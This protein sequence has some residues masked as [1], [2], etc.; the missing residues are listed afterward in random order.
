MK[1]K[2]ID[3]EPKI[4][5]LLRDLS[6]LNIGAYLAST[7]FDR[8]AI[9][10]GIENLWN[11]AIEAYEKSRKVIVL[12]PYD[13]THY[14][15]E[16]ALR[17]L[18]N[19]AIR[20]S[21]T[22]FNSIIIIILKGYL[23]WNTQAF[24]FEN[25]GEDLKLAGVPVEAVQKL[26]E[27]HNAKQRIIQ[28]IEAVQPNETS[29]DKKESEIAPNAFI[30]SKK[31]AWIDK[32]SKA[33][34]EG[35]LEDIK[36]YAKENSNVKLIKEIVNLSSRYHRIKDQNNKGTLKHEEKELEINKINEALVELILSL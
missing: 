28:S 23:K 35:T 36:Y 21:Q 34:I 1:I 22:D 32:T 8:F 25:I 2:M 9:Q 15:R 14:E 27:K 13:S 30:E 6:E 4:K 19:W 10:N 29:E 17:V 20:S 18:L 16:Q 3:I 24:F 12:S 33:D 11:N 7:E 31:T 5:P 26:K